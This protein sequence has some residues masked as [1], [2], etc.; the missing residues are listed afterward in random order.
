ML[1]NTAG[2]AAKK[3]KKPVQKVPKPLPPDGIKSNPSKRHRDR[4]NGELDRL[5]SL[6]PFPED[7]RARLDKLSVLRLSVGYL[8]VKSFFSAT[9]QKKDASWLADRT[10]AIGGNGKTASAI[11]G[12]AISE[13]DL[14]LQALNGF[15]L[16]VTA[17]GYIFYASPTIQDYLGFHQSDV[18][19]QSVFEMIHADDRAMFRRQ[20]HFAL[21]PNQGDPEQG[22]SGMQNSTQISNNV[23]A[24]DPQLVPPE[25]SSFLERSF[26]C[27]FRCLLDSSSGFLALNFQGRLKYLHGQNQVSE[28]G[29]VA[30]SM[31]ALFA[32]A[33]PL[34]PPSI[35][36]IRTKTLIFQTKHKLDFCPMGIDTRGKVVL[37][38]SEM[39]LCMKGSGYQ[40]IHA[41]DMMYCADNHMRMIKT[42]ESGMTVF[43]LLAKSGVWV[44]VQA[45]ARLVFKGGRPD[46]I[47]ARQRPL[48]NE[49]GEENFRKRRLQLPFNCSSGEALLYDTGPSLDMVEG[50]TPK[51][52]STSEV[53]DLDPKS[54]L[55]SMLN[56]DQSVYIQPPTPDPQLTL[57]KAFMDSHALLSV[58]GDAWQQEVS[59]PS[60]D[61]KQDP[62]V[63]GIMDSL[64]QIMSDGNLGAALE[65]LDVKDS[66]LKE[67]E[68]TLLKMNMSNDVSLEL[69]GI[70]ANDIFSYVEDALFKENA[71]G[72]RRSD[73]SRELGVPSSCF[74]DA[75]LGEQSAFTETSRGLSGAGLQDSGLPGNHQNAP[76]PAV[77]RQAQAVPQVDFVGIGEQSI[78]GAGSG[79][80][81][82]Q[83]VMCPDSLV[84]M[85]LNGPTVSQNGGMLSLRQPEFGAQTGLSLNNMM[86]YSSALATPCSQ[87]QVNQVRQGL[88]TMSS[89]GSCPQKMRS[90]PSSTV[91]PVHPESLVLSLP[92]QRQQVGIAGKHFEYQKR[93]TF[94]GQ[95]IQTA[96]EEQRGQW[97]PCIPNTN[98]EDNLQDVC[99]QNLPPQQSVSNPS[100]AQH[101]QGCFSVQTQSLP[102]QHL[103]PWQQQQNVSL[104]TCNRQQ[105]PLTHPP[106][107]SRQECHR[108]SSSGPVPHVSQNC[109]IVYGFGTQNATPASSSITNSCM[110]DGGLSSAGNGVCFSNVERGASVPPYQKLNPSNSQSSPQASCCFQ[111]LPGKLVLGPSSSSQGNGL[112]CPMAPGFSTGDTMAQ[113]QFLNC[114]GQTQVPGRPLEDNESFAFPPL[115]N[116]TAYFSENSQTNCCDF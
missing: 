11:D 48:T 39:E 23:V 97:T 18:V 10:A 84:S 20:L 32:I 12:V 55:G 45:N 44:W 43:R 82:M 1:G 68:H 28:D 87:T 77:L 71:M 29:T 34:Q 74:A 98:F 62:T 54:L 19:H 108:D 91:G 59:P 89:F 17:E 83:E 112:P 50:N 26:C 64:E 72:Q 60:T 114:N 30:H 8:K 49:E 46:F 69:N 14:L 109:R 115:S 31:L 25:N 22:S 100:S 94:I 93:Q 36:E 38:Y 16:V 106:I 80:G 35:L 70:L 86:P 96:L 95:S 61:L 76:L 105:Y 111:N 113:H 2:Y 65:D 41:A 42:G 66:E 15:V 99:A 101:L 88:P 37:G 27:R 40:F 7:V 81:G 92:N 51:T 24:Y 56:Q 5:T 4:L 47:I 107:P 102:P 3:R 110:F 58:P 21:N 57:D 13:G 67:W 73:G 63:A 52:R 116:G 79:V 9:L 103:H 78:V 75:L 53:Q 33:T 6:L 104:A 90:P 85:R